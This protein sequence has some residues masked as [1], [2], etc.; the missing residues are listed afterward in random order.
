MLL[1]RGMDVVERLKPDWRNYF[2]VYGDGLTD[3]NYAPKEIIMAVCD[4][5]ESDADNLIRE[6]NGAD[7]IPGTE[8]DVQLTIGQARSIL[9]LDAQKYAA[10]QSRITVDHLMRRVESVGRVGESKFK[11]VVI[12]KR[13][14]DGSL[15]YMAR[16]EE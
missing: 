8:D 16:L 11:V 2:S 9:G 4:V 7:G 1:V 10:L 6:R 14:D 3:L 15:N 5:P 13:Q 12:A